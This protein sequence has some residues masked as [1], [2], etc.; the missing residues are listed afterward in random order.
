MIHDFVVLNCPA[1]L[2]DVEFP[3]DR[4]ISFYSLD[5]PNC[6]AHLYS[7]DIREIKLVKRDSE[8]KTVMAQMIEEG[9]KKAAQNASYGKRWDAEVFETLCVAFGL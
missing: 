6:H 8:S 1:C 4:P 2:H 7:N 3:F 9:I 5:C